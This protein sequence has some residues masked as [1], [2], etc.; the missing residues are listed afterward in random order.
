MT[1]QIRVPPQR[2]SGSLPTFTATFGVYNQTEPWTNT[3][4]LTW[5]DLTAKLTAHEVGPKEGSCIVPATFS[6]TRR[7]KADAQ[8]IDLVMLDSDTGASLQEIVD[9]VTQQ[10]WSAVISS[11]HSHLTTTSRAKRGNWDG[12]RIATN[13]PDVAPSAFLEAEK[14]YLPRIAAGA[15][16]LAE[17]SE[18]VTFSHQPC[19]KFRLAIPLARPWLA[20][21]YDDQRK[22]NTAWKERIEALASV[23]R[24]SH[25]QACTDTS[26]LFYLPR[27]P[28]EGPPAEVAVLEGEPCDI[29]ALPLAAGRKAS[30]G[31]SGRKGRR[32]SADDEGSLGPQRYIDPDT[33]EI[34]DL[35]T[36]AR[37]SAGR[38]DI[39]KALQ[40]RRPEAFVG[41]VSDTVKHHIRCVSDDRH[42]DPGADGATMIIN[43][44][45]SASHGF[46]YHCRH[47]H[48]DGV[49]RL[50]FLRRMLEQ[51]WLKAADLTDGNFLVGDAP[52]R[53]RI[54]FVAGALPNV[55]DKAEQAL[56]DAKLSLYQ[57]GPFIV[58]P[59][60][61]MVTVSE[62]RTAAAQS[63][64]P[65][66]DHALVE[67]MT[68]AAD[69]ERFDRR[70]GDWATIDA[71]LKVATT[72]RQRVGRWRLP[73]LAGLVNAPTLRADGSILAAPGYDTATGLLLDM[74]GTDFPTISEQPDKA[75]AVQAL[76]LL[77][78]L[79]GT[80]PFVD[81]PD[82]AVALS[83]ILTACIRRALPTAP[84]HAFTAPT[85]GSGKSM[86]VDLVS[87]IS[88]GRE[89][90]VI[91]QGKT[92]EE[93][94]KRLSALLL[95]GDQV[96]AIDNCEAPLGGEFLC[97]MLTQPV[98]RARILCQS[99]APELPT[100]ACVTA[101]GNNL[102]LF[103]DM[104]RRAVV[105]RLD[106]RHERPEL[107]RF[108]SNPLSMARAD[109]ARYV[110][111]A[112]TILRAYHVAGRPGAP[113]PLGSFEDWSN[114]VRGALLWLGHA[115]PVDTIEAS[116][117]MDPKLDALGAVMAQW[118]A[119]IAGANVSVRDVIEIATGQR[120]EARGLPTAHPRPEYAEP[121][122]REA[123][124]VVAG[125]GGVINGKRLGRW[126]GRHQGR[127]VQGFRFVRAGMSAG[128]IRW[129][130][131]V[132]QAGDGAA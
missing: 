1:E 95:A 5:P 122:F 39:V 60:R 81:R 3:K 50:D 76:Q 123:L 91:A 11:T 118:H 26:R 70:S 129:R 19:P 67:L 119:A 51:G 106:P 124:L 68:Q 35:L 25:D 57:R 89:A 49:D 94:E 40:A 113:D 17:D 55:L 63:I 104:T 37:N 132:V 44:S 114:W 47:A 46:V 31:R 21:A 80:F 29:F 14:G 42:T 8:R 24:L 130:L 87:V 128:I 115:D 62:Q 58:R 71:P 98:V 127:I 88:S 61:V 53:P 34:V 121:D 54:R 36:W 109:R 10:G 7:K 107:R 9:A 85:A 84:M 27:R 28:A 56:L 126:L 43:A 41:K 69:W 45:E 99:K 12:F 52:A 112:L 111:A 110:A 72:Y 38:F 105:C 66:E 32:Q 2:S 48:C 100:N 116:R 102:V 90:G 15:R 4:S 18:Y 65:V 64:L 93:L 120:R 78:R 117:E 101:T 30:D 33:G 131:E 23:L 83:A 6:G 125:E 103:G 20:S 74:G 16:M 79:I 96:I 75:A 59:G 22:A 108:D 13:D 82:R 77:E 92:E 73:V 97:A 86:L